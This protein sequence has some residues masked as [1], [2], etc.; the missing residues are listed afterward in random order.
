LSPSGRI[1]TEE[2]IGE[3][4]ASRELLSHLRDLGTITGGRLPSRNEIAPAS[5]SASTKR[6][7]P[8]VAGSGRQ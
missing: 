6:F 1:F 8:S 4:L 5:S 3:V 7:K 2:S